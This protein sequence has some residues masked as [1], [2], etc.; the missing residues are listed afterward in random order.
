LKKRFPGGYWRSDAL[1]DKVAFKKAIEFIFS[2][3]RAFMSLT[4]YKILGFFFFGW[5][6]GIISMLFFISTLEILSNKRVRTLVLLI[7][8]YASPYFLTMSWFYRYRYPIEPL[9]LVL[10]CYIPILSFSKLYTQYG[11]T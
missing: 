6:I 4:Y 5:K 2:H 10:A 7:L 1:R 8:A 3:P 11:K 9:I